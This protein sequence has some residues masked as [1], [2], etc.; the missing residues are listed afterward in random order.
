MHRKSF[1]ASL[2]VALFVATPLFAQEEFTELHD[3][4]PDRCFSAAL[5]IVTAGAVDIGIESGYDPVTWK[6]KACI[7]ST[8]S[9][10]TGSVTDTFTVTVTAP[11]GMRIARIHYQQTGSRYLERST[12]WS[13]SGSGTLSVNGA[14]M[15]F[16]FT[17]PTLAMVAE[18]TDQNL[19]TAD[20]L[21][22]IALTARRNGNFPRVT[23]APGSATISV[24]N[25]VIRV[26][27]EPLSCTRGACV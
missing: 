11:A 27:Y 2:A 9:F 12:Y 4:I 13:A 21:I 3:L 20:V 22:T 15:P 17:T 18:I 25:A 5:S 1:A 8:R 24:T 16:S 26:E 6:N 14:A 19:D 10:H 23:A 7:A